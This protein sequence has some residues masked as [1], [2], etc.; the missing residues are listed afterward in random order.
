MDPGLNFLWLVDGVIV[1]TAVEGIVLLAHHRLTGGGPRPGSYLLNL[2]SGL[3]LMAALRCA[4]GG[5][6]TLWIALCLMAAGAAHGADMW[7]RWTAAAGAAGAAS[8]ASVRPQP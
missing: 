3:C 2:V 4:M 5:T 7:K 8:A 1:L 6:G